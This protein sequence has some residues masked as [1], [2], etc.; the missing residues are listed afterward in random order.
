MARGRARLGWLFGLFSAAT[1]AALLAVALVSLRWLTVEHRAAS[2]AAQADLAALEDAGAL[3]GLL[4]QKGFAAGYFLTAD[5]RWLDELHRATPAFEAWLERVTRDARTDASAQAVAA[6][7]AEYGRYD[8][9]RSRAIA[10]YQKGDR[11]GAVAL[12][13]ANSERAARLRELANKLIQ[14]RRDEVRARLAVADRDFTRGLYALA[15]T[16][17][18]TLFTAAAS[19]YLLAQRIARPIGELLR[20]IESGAPPVDADDEIGAL[21]AH[22]AR[23]AH[24]IAQAEKMSALGEVAAAVAHEVLN[25][26]TGV[27]MAL[28]VLARNPTSS[29]LRETVAAVD[30]EIRR[31]EGVAR[32]L[33]SFARPLTPQLRDCRLEEVVQSAVAATRAEAESRQQRVELA[34]DGVRSLQAD[35]ELL[36]Q[37]LVNLVTNACQASAQPGVVKLGARRDRGGVVLEVADH[38]SG[39]SPDVRARLFTPFVTT[40]KDGHGLG[41]AVS[42]NIALAHGG[43]IEARA[44][45][46]HGTVF[47]LWLPEVRA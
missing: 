21:S 27:K 11:D 10:Q 22:V 12:L 15:V 26:L 40:K 30:A 44:N 32:R 17:V 23:L 25:P 4:Y 18:L 35:P 41:L 31:V 8:A 13:T 33:V 46:P 39:L 16:M 9:D 5:A 7:V 28:Q 38:G 29:D 43:R 6:L 3:Q 42:Q 1:V 45:Q 24:Q 36:V 19:G 14:L 47:S 2:T 34:L 37:V 20:K